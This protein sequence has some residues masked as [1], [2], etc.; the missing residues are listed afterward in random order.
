LSNIM[1]QPYGLIH[2]SKS[3]FIS[4]KYNHLRDIP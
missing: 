1:P 3:L 4:K 2:I